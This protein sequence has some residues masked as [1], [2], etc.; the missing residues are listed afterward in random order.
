MSSPEQE[1]QAFKL[2]ARREEALTRAAK[3]AKNPEWKAL[4]N[5]KLDEL[6]QNEKARMLEGIRKNV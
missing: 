2:F 5:Q 4:W 1:R 6:I 3:R